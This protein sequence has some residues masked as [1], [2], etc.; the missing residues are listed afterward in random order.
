[1]GTCFIQLGYIITVSDSVNRFCSSQ[2]VGTYELG[3][4]QGPLCL[5]LVFVEQKASGLCVFGWRGGVPP[6][7]GN[8]VTF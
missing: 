5:E 2:N 1:M 3:K 6:A 7:P 4:G 8:G